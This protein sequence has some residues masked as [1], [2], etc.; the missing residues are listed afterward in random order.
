M[1][2]PKIIAD[3]QV[4]D[5]VIYHGYFGVGCA[6]KSVRTVERL[7]P[8]RVVVGEEHFP[9]GNLDTAFRIGG[10]GIYSRPHISIPKPGE[11]EKVALAERTA[12]LI[13]KLKNTHWSVVPYAKLR[14]IAKIIEREEE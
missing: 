2:E 7:T 1:P 6:V 4:G 14:L 8:T 3:L 10:G 12:N 13:G 5:V 11:A 9:K